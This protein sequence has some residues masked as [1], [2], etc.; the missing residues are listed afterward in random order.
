MAACQ[1]AHIAF[2]ECGQIYSR[3][4]SRPSEWWR[5]SELLRSPEGWYV[6][7]TRID[8]RRETAVVTAL[9]LDR[10]GEFEPVEARFQAIAAKPR[11]T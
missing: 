5:V 9:H 3:R 1:A 6:V 7:L 11:S 2:P 10:G 8:N 4:G